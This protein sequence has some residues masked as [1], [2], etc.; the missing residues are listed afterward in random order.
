MITPDYIG[1]LSL[2]VKNTTDNQI[3]RNDKK[4][5][6]GNNPNVYT[7]SDFLTNEECEHFINTSKS[8]LKRAL[9]SDSSK[10]VYSSGRTGSNCWLSHNYDDIIQ[11]VSNKIANEVGIPIE[12]SLIHI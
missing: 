7:I 1:N 12:L 3:E 8:K 11:R 10:G 6:Y 2:K 9:V 4:I 5:I